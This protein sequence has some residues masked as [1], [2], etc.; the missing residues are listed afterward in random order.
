MAFNGHGAPAGF[1][2]R[3]LLLGGT[4]VKSGASGMTDTYK[5]ITFDKTV[6]KD[7][8]KDKDAA[9]LRFKAS[10]IVYLSAD[11]TNGDADFAADEWHRVPINSLG[12]IKAAAA[13]N[14]SYII[15]VA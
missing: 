14:L 5:A 1:E 7:E 8:L 15:E 6:W 4:E 11:G 3:G 13:A 2:T 9:F 10:Q 12:Y